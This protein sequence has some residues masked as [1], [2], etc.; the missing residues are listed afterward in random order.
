M[1]GL[2]YTCNCYRHFFNPFKSSSCCLVPTAIDYGT[3]SF[4]VIHLDLEMQHLWGPRLL[5]CDPSLHQART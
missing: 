3:S 1:F 5:N 4:M 2:L